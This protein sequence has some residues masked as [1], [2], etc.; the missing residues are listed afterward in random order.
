MK[1]SSETDCSNDSLMALL[2]TRN[3]L[4]NGGGWGV[5]VWGERERERE[6][7]KERERNEEWM[8][9]KRQICKNEKINPRNKL[10]L[11]CK[12]ACRLK[13]MPI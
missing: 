1:D 3:P 9:G 10:H 7:N 5:C 13:H 12:N 2:I 6:Y 4:G 8:I 11:Q